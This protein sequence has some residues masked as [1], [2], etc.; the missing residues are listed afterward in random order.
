MLVLTP[1]H[2]KS[3]INYHIT[4]IDQEVHTNIT[5][6]LTNQ[7]RN[8]EP[9]TKEN[10]QQ[11]YKHSPDIIVKA[12][13]PFGYFN[14]KVQ[15]HIERQ[16]KHWHFYFNVQPGPRLIIKTLR[17]QLTGPGKNNKA[18]YQHKCNFTIKEK[19]TFLSAK[20]EK[21]KETWLQVAEKEGYITAE[22]SKH[23]VLVDPR[24]NEATI[25]L[26]LK[27]GPRYY[28]GPISFEQTILNKSFLRRYVS[29]KPSDI[30]SSQKLLDLQQVLSNSN[31]FRTVDIDPQLKKAKDNH[32]PIKVKLK[33]RKRQQYNLGFGFGTDTGIRESLAWIWRR[34][35]R[36]G[37]HF[38]ANFNASKRRSTFLASY[39]IP[40]HNPATDQWTIS[41]GIG[42]DHPSDGKSQTRQI[43]AAYSQIHPTWRRT[44]SLSYQ[45]EHYRLNN[46]S[47]YQNA[48]ILLPSTQWTW[49]DRDDPLFTRKGHRLDWQLRGAAEHLFSVTSF[50]QTQLSAKL[51]VPMGSKSRVLTR[52]TVGGTFGKNLNDKLP[53]TLRYFSGGS[54]SVRGYGYQDLGPGN[55]IIQSSFEYQQ[56]LVQ[57]WYATGFFDA[58]NAENHFVMRL[59]QGVGI[60]VLWVSPIGPIAV[61]LAKTLNRDRHPTRIQIAMGPDLVV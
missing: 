27:T 10:I 13:Q 50:I 59:N 20:Y 52:A 19:Q 36:D 58:G 8:Y 35:N 44:Y 18:L 4:G 31:Y 21:A 1:T 3:Q 40:A 25:E 34:L 6:T 28:F 14:A 47:M 45:R 38:S 43:T 48:G 39:Y 11:F 15:H 54:R 49:L 33:S 57:K 26:T 22:L 53:L 12:L 32:I 9:Y 17:L 29:F 23:T 7:A 5:V 30:Y 2:A 60:G 56:H 61:T 16:G 46:E 55:F 42:N 41:V 51:I 37:H 24:S